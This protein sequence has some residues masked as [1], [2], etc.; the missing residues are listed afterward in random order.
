MA[1]EL[2]KKTGCRLELAHNCTVTRKNISGAKDIVQWF[3][4]KPE[5]SHIWR[6]LSFQPEADTGRTLF[7]DHPITPQDVWDQIQEGTGR[8]LRRD[9]TIFGHPDCNSWAPLLV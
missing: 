8:P 3:L 4:E 6:M 7:S 5:R 1:L 2:R 9:A